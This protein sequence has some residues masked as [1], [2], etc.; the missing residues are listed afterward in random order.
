MRCRHL[1]S[2]ACLVTASL[3]CFRASALE[4]PRAHGTW[5]VAFYSNGDNDLEYN[6][7]QDLFEA[8]YVGSTPIETLRQTGQGLQVV[9]LLDTKQAYSGRTHFIQVRHTSLESLPPDDGRPPAWAGLVEPFGDDSEANMADGKTLEAFLN[10]ASHCYPAEHFALVV[11]G[12]GAGARATSG[13]TESD[14]NARTFG[15]DETPSS[16]K[17][18]FVEE[19]VDAIHQAMGPHPLDVVALDAC[20]MSTLEVGFAFK[21]VANLLVAS[22]DLEGP[23]GWDHSSW[24]SELKRKPTIERDTIASLMVTSYPNAINA[25]S[26]AERTQWGKRYTLAVTHLDPLPTPH[27]CAHRGVIGL[28]ETVD[29]LGGAIRTAQLQRE[30]MLARGSCRCLGT[31]SQPVNADLM[32][33]LGAFGERIR[34][35]DGVDS[36]QVRELVLRARSELECVTSERTVAAALRGAHNDPAGLSVF[37]PPTRK[38][39]RDVGLGKVAIYNDQLTHKVTIT[40]SEPDFPVRFFTHARKWTSLL[41]DERLGDVDS[42]LR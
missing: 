27:Q 29:L 18:L 25:Y 42:T 34:H 1:L 5:T 32:C 26:S 12:H 28:V 16:D 19:V 15:R 22:E 21:R 40:M 4:C 14:N 41:N 8:A 3:V 36:E 7:V 17:F 38:L 11:N 10:H 31:R 37:L 35:H 39:F 30:F 2:T 23:D 13:S 33:V 24:L 20:L 6:L 9:M